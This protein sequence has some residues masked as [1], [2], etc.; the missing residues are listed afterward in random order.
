MKVCYHF[1]FINSRAVKNEWNDLTFKFYNDGTVV[2][3]DNDTNNRIHPRQ[4]TGAAQDFYIRKRIY[5]IKI[6]LQEKRLKYA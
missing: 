6:N 5:L 1:R 3:I 2:I 4:L